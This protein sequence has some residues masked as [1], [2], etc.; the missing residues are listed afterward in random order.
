MLKN[1]DIKGNIVAIVRGTIRNTSLKNLIAFKKK[2]GDGK[3]KNTVN[4]LKA[5]QKLKKIIREPKAKYLRTKT[6]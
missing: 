3:C 4:T 1:W 2:K 6:T 5:L